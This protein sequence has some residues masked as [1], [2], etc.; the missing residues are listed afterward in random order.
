MANC[1]VTLNGQTLYP[2]LPITRT[3]LRIADSKRMLN[4]QLREARRAEKYEF[5]LTLSDASEAERTV[6]LAAAGATGSCAYT[7]ETGTART[8][9]ARLSQD[10]L[11]TTAPD[12]DGGLSATGPATY[13]LAISVVEV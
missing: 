3:P 5:E 10:D 2:A 13:D 8:V 9:I 7:D 6:W 4:G 11:A 1:Y 12:V